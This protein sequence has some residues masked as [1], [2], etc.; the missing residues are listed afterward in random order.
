MKLIKMTRTIDGSIQDGELSGGTAGQVPF[1]S[2]PDT[3]D[4]TGPGTAGQVLMSTGGSAP[5]FQTLPSSAN[6]PGGTAGQVVYQ[7]APSTTTFTGP[8]TS[9]QVLT[10]TGG[11]APT[12][13][14][15]S[16]VPSANNITGGSA[17]LVLYQSAPGVTSGAGPGTSGQVLTSNGAAP[18]T[19]QNVSLATN[20][21]NLSSGTA[22]QIPYQTAPGLTGF[23]GPGSAGQ[24]LTSNG[25]GAPTYTTLITAPTANSI[26]AGAANQVLYQSAS[27]TT[28]FAGPGTSGQILT[29][30]GSGVPTFQTLTVV[31]RATNISGGT[32]GQIP[33]QSAVDTTDFVGPGTSGQFLRSNGAAP[34]SFASV[35]AQPPTY[36]IYTSG[37]GTYI[38]PA[39]VQY[40][41]VEMVG[42]GGGGGMNN[43][44]SATGGGGGSSCYLKL[45]VNTGN[46]N[47]TVGLGGPGG[48][49]GGAFPSDGTNGTAT[50]FGLASCL[51]GGKGNAVANFFGGI[52]GAY[53]AGGYTILYAVD[54]QNGWD[55]ISSGQIKSAPGGSSFLGI[56][57]SSVTSSNTAVPTGIVGGHGTGGTG[58]N[59]NFP[60]APSGC[61]GAPGL[62]VITEV[63]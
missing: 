40:L 28:A 47:Y 23:A 20:A 37:T 15:L 41:I 60:S 51:G 45:R 46:Y 58:L 56:A 12:F 32:V 19:Y 4:F 54:G 8:G 26:A 7:S 35:T 52:A 3:T 43:A 16:T 5:T 53:G 61:A 59:T 18:P 13:Q 62:I 44:G 24:Y 14:T 11:T 2:A 33:Y 6:I 34:P 36:T 63:Y 39:G 17:G 25:T 31:P 1:Q 49:S 57:G 29:A 30:N 55:G 10:S 42:G 9:G 48:I 22:G 38:A 21:S 27:S 50:A